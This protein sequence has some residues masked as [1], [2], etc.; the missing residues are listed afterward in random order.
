MRSLRL[1][2]FHRA[3]PS[4]ALDE[5]VSLLSRRS[6]PCNKP[7]S[8]SAVARRSGKLHSQSCTRRVPRMQRVDARGPIS[9]A[10]TPQ[11]GQAET[12]GDLERWVAADRR[13]GGCVGP[14]R[15]VSPWERPCQTCGG[16]PQTVVA[17]QRKGRAANPSP[18][19]AGRSAHR[20]AA[21]R[22]WGRLGKAERLDETDQLAIVFQLVEEPVGTRPAKGVPRSAS[23]G[24]TSERSRSG[25]QI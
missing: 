20:S 15:T 19:L 4:T 13:P 16:P 6:T 7:A 24:H 17:N 12:P 23:V 22:P 8:K 25:T 21:V 14:W 9:G 18:M 11:P 3:C 10:S 5:R 2:R 1:P